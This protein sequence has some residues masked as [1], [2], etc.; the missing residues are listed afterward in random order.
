MDIV[1]AGHRPWSELWLP[2]RGCGCQP[3]KKG[4]CRIGNSTQSSLKG[5]HNA[6]VTA[7]EDALPVC[8]CLRLGLSW[9]SVQPLPSGWSQV[10]MENTGQLYFL[11][12]LHYVKSQTHCFDCLMTCKLVWTLEKTM[13]DHLL[14]PSGTIPH[15]PRWSLELLDHR[16]S[17]S[18]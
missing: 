8:F 12:G 7:E 17:V 13:T 18:P 1:S 5:I 11:H 10:G 14:G 16:D 2:P 4:W 15:N 6:A 9:F 3:G